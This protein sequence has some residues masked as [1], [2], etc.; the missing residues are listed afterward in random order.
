VF[1]RLAE[2][3]LFHGKDQ[4]GKSEKTLRAYNYRLGFFLDCTAQQDLRYLDH[5]D[6]KQLLPLREVPVRSRKRP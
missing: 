5:I 3:P 4:Q 6:R 1:Q 2:L